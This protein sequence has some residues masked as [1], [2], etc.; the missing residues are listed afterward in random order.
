MW[1]FFFFF[2]LTPYIGFLAQIT[3][4][5]YLLALTKKSDILSLGIMETLQ[6]G[7][8]PRA[9][10]WWHITSTEILAALV[11]VVCLLSELLACPAARVVD[12][13]VWSV[14]YTG[15]SWMP[16]KCCDL[17]AI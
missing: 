3:V 6:P 2:N 10:R 1:L 8:L 13:D 11:L 7:P 17:S 12:A 4:A 9:K 5:H 15:F 14:E 16:G